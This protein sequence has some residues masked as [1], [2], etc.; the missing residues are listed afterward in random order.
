MTGGVPLD[1]AR[2]AGG[3]A[4]ALTIET[5]LTIAVPRHPRRSDTGRSRLPVDLLAPFAGQKGA[6]QKA[7]TR[8]VDHLLAEGAFH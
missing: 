7:S 6:G 1:D 4:R 2:L 8:A 3:N 5:T